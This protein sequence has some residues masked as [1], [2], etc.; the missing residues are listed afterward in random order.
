MA[1]GTSLTWKRK[2]AHITGVKQETDDGEFVRKKLK[3]SDLP[4]AGTQR[5]AIDALLLTFKKSG[6]F[7]K[8]RKA[9]FAQFEQ[10][11]IYINL[12]YVSTLLTGFQEAKSRMTQSLEELTETEID[13]QANYL[14]SKER[15]QAAALLEGAAERSDIYR[16]AE[17]D[18][19]KLVQ[20]LLTQAEDAMRDIRRKEIGEEA[21]VIE[22]ERGSRTEED[23]VREFEERRQARIQAAEEESEKIKQKE[24]EEKQKAEE[25]R[26]KRKE[27]EEA[28]EKELEKEQEEREAKR[29]AEREEREA[30][31]QAEREE[32]E[33]ERERGYE[34][35]REERRE[36]R[37]REE[38][39]IR[40]ESRERN[41]RT[42]DRS[43]HRDRARDRSR[44]RSTD[45]GVVDARLPTTDKDL[46][47][48]ALEELLREGQRLARSQARPELE[49]DD[50]LEPPPRKILPPKSIVPRDPVAARLAKLDRPSIKS[51]TKSSVP[52]TPSKRDEGSRAPSAIPSVEKARDTELS[53]RRRSRSRSRDRRES[54]RYS[55]LPDDRRSSRYDDERR[56]SHYPD[57]DRRHSSR[58]EEDR[59]AYRDRHRSSRYDDDRESRRD[60][61]R[62]SYRGGMDSYR[63][64]RRDPSRDRSRSRDRRRERSRSR[65]RPRERSRSRSRS[66]RRGARD[67]SYSPRPSRRAARSR[68]P[69]AEI[70]R[71]VPSTSRRSPIPSSISRRREERERERPDRGDS[72]RAGD[73]DRDRDR[74]DSY[75]ERDRD[76][77]RRYGLDEIDRYVPGQSG[78][79]GRDN[80]ESRRK[81]RERERSP[82]RTRD[83]EGKDRDRDRDTRDRE[84]DREREKSDKDRDRR[85]S[86]IKDSTKD[87]RRSRSTS[88]PKN[89]LS[90][91]FEKES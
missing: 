42:R 71:Y 86:V 14:L 70:D 26:R 47:A 13:R 56:S 40:E 78:A 22:A 57:D 15:R 49:K 73:R 77:R 65:D 24:R 19:D 44:R 46:E 8:L 41:A 5:S 83:R 18:I 11:V 7:D 61:S 58:F 87:S 39:R 81:D 48:I 28:R 52:A 31:R 84:K 54:R 23:Y 59:D 29:K 62:D 60:R 90:K 4:I 51:E 43:R 63:G 37:K 1:Q 3:L 34:R 64:S 25:E 75:R 6:E 12:E 10:S 91:F 80:D 68:T 55:P 27:E 9:V 2:S 67:R 76:E 35:E 32:K 79:R 72:Y 33:R 88:K 30:K 53:D 89:P 69:V 17:N 50:T 45:R 38:E 82:S 36:R 66:R 21:A 74:R 16:T 20:E 85:E